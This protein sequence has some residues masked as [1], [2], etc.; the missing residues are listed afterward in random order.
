MV[1]HFAWDEGAAFE[2]HDFGYM[3]GI[4]SYYYNYYLGYMKNGKIYPWGPYTADGTLK[5]ILEKSSSFA[6]DLYYLFDRIGEDQI[7]EELRKEFEYENFM[8]EKVI[9]VKYLPIENLPVG[10]FIKT[11]Y[12]LIKDV[13]EYEKDQNSTDLFYDTVT[14]SVYAEMIKNEFIFGKK[15]AKDDEEIVHNASDYM[16]YAYPDYDSKE[17][18]SFYLRTAAEAMRTYTMEDD[19]IWVILE[20]EG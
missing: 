9:V 6:S 10:S 16:Y 17:Y 20:T 8:G 1:A 19:V 14:P 18:E 4:M 2:S 12:F 7:S 11:G 13:I 15:E 5:Q 3:E